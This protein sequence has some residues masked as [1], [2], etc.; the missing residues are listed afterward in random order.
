MVILLYLIYNKMS[1]IITENDEEFIKSECNCDICTEY[2]IIKN[3]W[4][5]FKPKTRLQ[6]RMLR[7]VNRIEKKIKRKNKRKKNNTKK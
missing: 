3:D 4:E 2:N 7:V 6:L 1:L 5:K